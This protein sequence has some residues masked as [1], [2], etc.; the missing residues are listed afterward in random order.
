MDFGES[1]EFVGFGEFVLVELEEVIVGFGANFIVEFGH[2]LFECFEMFGVKSRVFMV[3][4]CLIMSEGMEDLVGFV[5]ESFN[6]FFITGTIFLVM[7]ELPGPLFIH[8]AEVDFAVK[9]EF[10]VFFPESQL[11]FLFLLILFIVFIKFLYEQSE[12]FLCFLKG[13]HLLEI[14]A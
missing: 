5:L 1:S 14:Q 13:F 4:L 10:L 7:G 9:I 12:H 6:G 11:G 2:F 3:G 8:L